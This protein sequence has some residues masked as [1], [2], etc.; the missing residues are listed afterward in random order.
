M[1]PASFEAQAARS[2]DTTAVVCGDNVLT[3]GALNAQ[4]DRLA[5]VLSGLGAGPEAVVAVAVERSAELLTALLAILKTG[6]AYLPVDPSHPANRIEYILADAEPAVIVDQG[7]SRRGAIAPGQGAD[8]P[9]K[10]GGPGKNQRSGS[11]SASVALARC[12]LNIR[13]M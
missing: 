7:D 3:Y 11:Q 13:R 5:A 2:P 6:A 9:N 12:C 8:T 10:R 1:L 4:A